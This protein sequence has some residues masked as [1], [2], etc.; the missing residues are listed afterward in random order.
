MVN[1]EPPEFVRVTDCAWLVPTDMLPKL[2]VAGLTVSWP[3]PADACEV[4]ARIVEKKKNRRN[5]SVISLQLK[6]ELFTV[7]PQYAALELRGGG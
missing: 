3:L 7:R 1:F 5:R 4:S 2:R 6:L